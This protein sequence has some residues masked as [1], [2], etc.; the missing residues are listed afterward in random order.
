LPVSRR[1]VRLF[2]ILAVASVFATGIGF[3]PP[4][5]SPVA[6]GGPKVVII[7]GPVKNLTDNYRARGD[8]VA[9]AAQAA[10]ATVVKVYS[11]NATWANVRAAVNGAN[12]IVYFGH[13]NG[14]P[15]P[16]TE[17]FEYTDRVNGW[18][19]NRTTT[20]GDDDN[21]STTMV[22]CGEKALLGTMAADDGAAQRQY[23][24]YPNNDGITPA[25][26]FTMVY[27][28]AHYTAG[29]GERYDE[30]TPIT[31]LAEA[32]QRVRNY[33]TPIL[34]LGGS[35]IATAYGDAAEIVERV[36]AQADTA[37]G[38]IFAAG[39]GYS[40][41]TLT[42]AAHP[43]FPALQYWVQRTVIENF[44]FDDP[45][46]WYAF[47]G[48]PTRAPGG[49]NGGAFSDIYS[50]PF[51]NDILWLHEAGIT[52]GC[53]G[54]RFCPNQSVTRAQ[55][56]SFLV[57]ALDLPP[58]TQD[59]FGD[60]TSSM[61]QADINALHAAGIT[62]GCDDGAYCPNQAV[63]RAQMAS[64]LTRAL[65]V[66]ASSQDA[67]TDDD[68]SMHEA[69]INAVAAAGIAGGCG[70]TSYCPNNPVTRGQMAAFLHRALD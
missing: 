52:G 65:G 61:H 29:F 56:A 44:H 47:A 70:P 22:Y 28:Q 69:D 54:G 8:R 49:G 7:V 43:D 9:D 50:S 13:G 25:P 27:G 26:G 33:A 58:A 1:I 20:N 51:Y 5:V 3:A 11:P 42:S 30:E 14:Y 55:M 60:D 17:G 66:A 12:V 24:G 6:A 68:G 35:Y 39:E 41:S 45:D 4:A 16:Y 40:P 15:N 18:G 48:D 53:G 37:Y 63:T 62:G 57:R 59:Y 23:C 67:F 19:L 46:Y 21:W 36:L 38:E 64:F 32:Q 2:T 10:G 31:T 34:A